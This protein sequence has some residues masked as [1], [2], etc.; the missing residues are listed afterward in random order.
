M[1]G[2]TSTEKPWSNQV[3]IGDPY[4]QLTD[5]EVVELKAAVRQLES[6]NLI[7]ARTSFASLTSRA[8]GDIAVAIWQQESRLAWAERRAS[9]I[10]GITD[11]AESNRVELRE[12]YREEAKSRPS[13]LAYFLAARIEDD[14]LA[15]QLLLKEAL[16]IDPQM[17]WAHYALAHLAAN[18][19]DW[20]TARSELKRTFELQ[21]DHLPSIRLYGWLQAE[22]GKTESAILALES[23]LERSQ[24]D[25]LATDSIRN[26]VKLDLA[27][28]YTSNGDEGDALKLLKSLKLDGADEARRLTALAVIEQGRENYPAA[29]RALQAAQ[30]VEPESLLPF[31]Q[32]ALLCEFWLADVDRA[33]ELWSHVIMLASDSEELSAGMQGFRAE[34]HLQRLNREHPRSLEMTE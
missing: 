10:P 22:A 33:R 21:A 20:V 25:L 15:A 6:R 24:E 11:A 17:A 4:A 16:E 9:L 14:F 27:L 30:V 31:V 28:A 2:C 13:S 8:Q 18:S 23:W 32:E 1:G 26:Q 19:G 3:S 7:S 29:R 34:F 5:T 12:Y